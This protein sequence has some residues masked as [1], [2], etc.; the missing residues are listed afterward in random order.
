MPKIVSVILGSP[1]YGNSDKLAEAFI[2][3]LMEKGTIVH[4][5]VV[6]EM[7]IGGCMG[8]EYCY[9]HAGNC[10]QNDDMQK[11]YDYLSETDT[12][13][14]VTP[15]YYQSFPSQM[16]ALIDRLYVTENR[17]F[18]IKDAVLLATYATP[19]EEMS[20]EI[21][22][23]FETLISYHKWENRGIIVVSGLDEKDDIVGNQALVEAKELGRQI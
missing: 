4:K 2:C 9:S 22:H 17:R 12:I 5:I 7:Q 19:G 23:Y 6:K 8:C 13:V 10:R 1:R 11:V 20:L 15:V 18:P 3:G 14:F 21:I 16:K